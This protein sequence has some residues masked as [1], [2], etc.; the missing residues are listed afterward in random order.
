MSAFAP[1][2]AALAVALVVLAALSAAPNVA[3]AADEDVVTKMS[4]ARIE[5][6]MN[7]FN[8]VKNFKELDDGTYSFETGG[9]KVVVFN[10]GDSLQLFAGFAGKATLSR[11][12]EWNRTKRFTRAY[13]TEKGE[14]VLE[15]DLEL[16]GGVTEKNVK[17]WMKTYVLC[18]KAFKKHLEE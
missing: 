11:I 12:N 4:A 6:I 8:D 1:T 5:R 13:T 14:P 16:T 18:L 7:S 3:R 15:S 17:E 9:L 10:K 2:R